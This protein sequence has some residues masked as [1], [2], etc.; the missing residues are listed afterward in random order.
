MRKLALALVALSAG[1]AWAQ[2]PTSFVV[3]TEKWRATV[4]WTAV[5]PDYPPAPR[6]FDGPVNYTRITVYAGQAGG[7]VV[8]QWGGPPVVGSP[9]PSF[10]SDDGRL[11]VQFRG[12][13]TAVSLTDYS[14]DVR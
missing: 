12:V 6:E 13:V 8:S 7:P 10:V 2:G 9:G 5:P 4:R 3:V 14:A 1:P 11:R